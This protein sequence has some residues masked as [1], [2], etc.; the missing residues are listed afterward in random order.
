MT[1]KMRFAIVGAGVISPLHARAIVNHPEAELTAIVDEVQEKAEAL[2]KEFGSPPIY[3][4]L[5]Q[6]L[7]EGEVDAVCICVPSGLHRDVTVAAA[8]AGKHVLCEKPLGITAKDMDEMIEACRSNGVKL[9]TVFQKRTTEAALLTKKAV[10]EGKLGR[11]VLGDAYLKYY[12]SREYYK[13]AGWRGTWLLDGGGALMNQGVHG[14]DIIRWLMGDVESVFAYAAPLIHDIE[15]EDTAVAV[16]KYTSGAY[17]V[18]QGTTTVNP[19]QEA[20]FEIHGEHGSIIYGDSGF[21]VWKTIDGDEAPGSSLKGAA[22][23]TDDPQAISSDGHYIL[24]DDLIKAVR[25]NREPLI[26]GEEARKSVDLILAIYES[27][28]TGR[29]VRLKPGGAA[30]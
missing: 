7:K 9:A 17:G 29:E 16:L 4:T 6:M 18:I 12:R 21:K 3:A 26:S 23:G 20:R 11:L 8:R 22:D 13:S 25:Q 27:A 14:V 1:K 19:G 10:D 5:E 28:R 2:A 30:L 15:V 24:V